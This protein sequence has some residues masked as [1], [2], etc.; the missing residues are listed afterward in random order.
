MRAHVPIQT[1]VRL[2]VPGR[3]VS[4]SRPRGRFRVVLGFLR[5]LDSTMDH[6]SLVTCAATSNN[7]PKSAR[8]SLRPTSTASTRSILLPTPWSEDMANQSQSIKRVALRTASLLKGNN[9][10]CACAPP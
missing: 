8:T 10:P 2:D 3:H 4:S 7:A 9:A 1:R 5:V 6:T